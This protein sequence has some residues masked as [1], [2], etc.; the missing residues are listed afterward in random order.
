MI[1]NLLIFVQDEKGKRPSFDAPP[2]GPDV[3]QIG[4]AAT[5]PSTNIALETEAG[6]SQGRK[7]MEPSPSGNATAM[8]EHD[9]KFEEETNSN[10]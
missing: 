2:S 10:Q 6:E 4:G 9:G 7:T 1:E 3:S 8:E 5:I